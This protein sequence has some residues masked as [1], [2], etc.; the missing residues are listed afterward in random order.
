MLG[1]GVLDMLLGY[2][3]L[4]DQKMRCHQSCGRFDVTD[5]ITPR[6]NLRGELDFD[7]SAPNGVKVGFPAL[8]EGIAADLAD[9]LVL[10]PLALAANFVRVLGTSGRD[11]TGMLVNVPI[12]LADAP[13][14]RRILLLSDDAVHAELDEEGTNGMDDWGV[15]DVDGEV[16]GRKNTDGLLLRGGLK[17]TLD[18][19]RMIDGDSVGKGCDCFGFEGVVDVCKGAVRRCW[20][21][22]GQEVGK[23]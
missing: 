2:D 17:G 12:D 22:A 18:A 3:D 21:M 6:A 14:G 1:V 15:N 23:G 4:D 5:G 10:L 20:E 13:T 9:I 8:L 16:G 7:L 11:I 19:E